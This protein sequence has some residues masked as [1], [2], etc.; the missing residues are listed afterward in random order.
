MWLLNLFSKF[1]KAAFLFPPYLVGKIQLS[2]NTLVHKILKQ[3]FGCRSQPV[4][5]LILR[6]SLRKSA[7]LTKIVRASDAT[8]S[9]AFLFPAYS[10]GNACVAKYAPQLRISSSC[11]FVGKCLRR[12]APL[13][14]LNLFS[15]FFKAAF[16]FPPYLV[17]KIQLSQNTLVHKI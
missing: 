14:L 9:C 3:R 17:G 12:F 6:Y 1:F 8:T 13:W 2:Q 4:R 16:L 7:V 5:F 15:K 10:S 11:L